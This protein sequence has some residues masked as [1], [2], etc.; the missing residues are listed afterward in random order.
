[1]AQVQGQIAAE[2]IAATANAV[3]NHLTRLER[4]GRIMRFDDGRFGFAFV[5][6]E[7][8]AEESDFVRAARTPADDDI[9]F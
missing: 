1:T 9:P 5:G 6:V 7:P 2:G 8:G 3:R 4:D